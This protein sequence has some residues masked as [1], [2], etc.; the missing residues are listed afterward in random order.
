MKVTV[1]ALPASTLEV[2]RAEDFAYCWTIVAVIVNWALLLE[3]VQ[4]L[5]FELLYA[6]LPFDVPTVSDYRL[7][8]ATKKN[9]LKNLPLRPTD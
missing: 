1:D 4:T 3:Y 2:T 6:T 9:R 7:S 8:H 5:P